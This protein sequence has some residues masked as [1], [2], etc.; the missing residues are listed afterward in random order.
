[1]T[2][3]HH[4][5]KILLTLIWTCEIFL[6]IRKIKTWSCSLQTWRSL[7]NVTCNVT[8]LQSVWTVSPLK[9]QLKPSSPVVTQGPPPTGSPAP[10]SSTSSLERPSCTPAWLATSC[11]VSPFSTVSLGTHPS[12]VGCHLSAKVRNCSLRS[13]LH[14][15]KSASAVQCPSILPLKMH[16]LILDLRWKN[17]NNL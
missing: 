3:H 16:D 15:F 6:A 17:K 9:L 1:M 7:R 13:S 14:Y 12:G 5:E 8:F 4:A 11:W 2:D 10:T